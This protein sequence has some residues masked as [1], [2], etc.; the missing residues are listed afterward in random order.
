MA[1][2]DVRALGRRK[3][4]MDDFS[5]PFPP[6]D[7]DGDGSRLLRDV[8]AQVVR[9]EVAEFEKRQDENQFLKAL[10]PQDIDEA[11]STGKVI[12]GGSDLA[13]Q[14]VDVEYAVDNA[15][16]AFADGIFLVVIDGEQVEDLDAEVHVNEDS[17]ISFCPTHASCRRIAPRFL[18]PLDQRCFWSA[19]VTVLPQRGDLMLNR[20]QARDMLA[21]FTVDVDDEGDRVLLVVDRV[22]KLPKKLREIAFHVLGRD[23]SGGTTESIKRGARPTEYEKLLALKPAERGKIFEAFCGAAGQ[24]FARAIAWRQQQSR[25]GGTVLRFEEAGTLDLGGLVATAFELGS[26]IDPQVTTVTWLAEWVS[27][28]KQVGSGYHWS[29]S[30]DRFA[31]VFCA[32]VDAGGKEADT[33]LDI[34]SDTLKGDHATAVYDSHVMRT[35]LAVDR[36]EAWDLVAKTLLA[37]QRQEGLRNNIVGAVSSAHPEALVKLLAVIRENK[38][39]RFTSVWSSLANLFGFL[40]V[41]RGGMVNDMTAKQIR[42][43]LETACEMLAENNPHRIAAAEND[44]ERYWFALWATG[45]QSVE[46]ARK[47][48]VQRLDDRDDAIRFVGLQ[49]LRFAESPVDDS[50]AELVNDSNP[51]VADAAFWLICSNPARNDTKLPQKTQAKRFEA[52]ESYVA[53]LPQKSFTLD[54]IVWPWTAWSVDPKSCLLSVAPSSWRSATHTSPTASRTLRHLS[55]AKRDQA[56]LATEEVG[57]RN[58]RVTA[59]TRDG[60]INGCRRLC[61]RGPCRTRTHRCRGGCSRRPAHA[62]GRR[63]AASGLPRNQITSQGRPANLSITTPQLR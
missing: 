21:P 18:C 6:D 3:K 35:L 4:L 55:S 26:Y 41:D 37:A 40:A 59:P 58:T 14:Q 20:E 34:I 2:I 28:L 63:P 54:P 12:P 39:A 27:H 46:Q 7:G 15:L 47:V 16:T 56:A 33:V 11:A 23:S 36:P 62:V 9:S 32:A 61:S 45:C 10:S 49:F 1:T 50:A 13:P 30:A 52:I 25:V 31:D 44:P 17:R 48:A 51:Q 8:I 60:S 43:C 38:L 53:R 22:K 29:L 19:F 57:Q 24:P 42:V 5:V